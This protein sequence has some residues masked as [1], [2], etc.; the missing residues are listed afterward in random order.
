MQLPTALL[1]IEAEV[2]TRFQ[3]EL[4]S[5][6][7]SQSLLLFNNFFNCF[8]V[9]FP[10]DVCPT[11][12]GEHLCIVNVISRERSLPFLDEVKIGL[13]KIPCR[14]EELAIEESHVVDKVVTNYWL[15]FS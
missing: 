8:E 10:K 12:L 7:V 9:C 4:N 11:R 15:L 5:H 13:R 2:W 6:I 1:L 3:V 14:G